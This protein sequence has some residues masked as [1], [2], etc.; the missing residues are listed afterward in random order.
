M[1]RMRLHLVH[2]NRPRLN[3]SSKFESFFAVIDVIN[4]TSEKIYAL[5]IERSNAAGRYL[6]GISLALVPGR[7]GHKCQQQRWV[8][9]RFIRREIGKYQVELTA[10]AIKR[11]E[12][13]NSTKLSTWAEASTSRVEI[14][15]VVETFSDLILT[16]KLNGFGSHLMELWVETIP[17]PTRFSHRTEKETFLKHSRHS[18][19]TALQRKVKEKL[20]ESLCFKTYGTDFGKRCCELKRES[21]SRESTP[22][23]DTDFCRK[24]RQAKC[25]KFL[26]LLTSSSVIGKHESDYSSIS[27]ASINKMCSVIVAGSFQGVWRA[28]MGSGIAYCGKLFAFRNSGNFLWC[29]VGGR[30]KFPKLARIG[31]S[32]AALSAIGLPE[33]FFYIT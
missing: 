13:C 33:V 16:K 21:F 23:D 3:V 12:K 9:R 28:Q 14:Q 20:S 31:F 17:K 10:I 11:L 30:Q 7:A 15:L 1:A 4:L 5:S 19:S 24:V 25:F 27:T 26:P 18:H 29:A 8:M 2:R 22:A 6:K 32:V